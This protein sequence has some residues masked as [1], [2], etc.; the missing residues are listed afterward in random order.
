MRRSGTVIGRVCHTMRVRRRSSPTS[1]T[2]DRSAAVLWLITDRDPK[3]TAD[4]TS[5]SGHTIEN[6][7]CFFLLSTASRRLNPHVASWKR[8]SCEQQLDLSVDE[9]DQRDATSE[10]R[11]P[12]KLP[13][14]VAS[15]NC[16]WLTSACPEVLEPLL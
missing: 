5:A 4:Q 8:V 6:Q 13:V 9:H 1:G 12:W 3:A 11:T 15:K 2:V 7:G 10:M 14:H 16:V